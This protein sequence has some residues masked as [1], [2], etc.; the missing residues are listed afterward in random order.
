MNVY[1]ICNTNEVSSCSLVGMQ[2]VTIVLVGMYFV[3]VVL[4]GM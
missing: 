1:R 3:T 4:I 2:F